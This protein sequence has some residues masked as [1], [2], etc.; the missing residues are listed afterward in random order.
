MAVGPEPSVNGRPG[1]SPWTSLLIFVGL[2]FLLSWSAW[3]ILLATGGD[4]TAGTLP[5]LLWV[6]GGF[7]PT[8]AALA[9]ARLDGRP[10]FRRLLRELIRWRVGWKWYLL[11]LLP[12]GVA[13]TS[14]LV[15]GADTSSDT[16]ILAA[17]TATLSAFLVNALVAGGNEELGW[18][19]YAQPS[20]QRIIRPLWASLVVGVIWALWH[21][22]L[23][24]MSGTSQ[25]DSSFIWFTI[26]AVALS[27]ILAWSYNGT[28]RS[29]LV[30]LLIHASVNTFYAAAVTFED[31]IDFAQFEV[32]ASL[33]MS[34]AA[35][36]VAILNGISLGRRRRTPRTQSPGERTEPQDRGTNT[37]NEIDPSNRGG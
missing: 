16:S 31:S 13:A 35:V 34:A 12:A 27:I 7:G 24:L 17:L 11:I 30:P 9:T 19:G 6:A 4:P 8:A 36:V 5:L 26:Q 25:A 3:G 32:V 37:H 22:P 1:H 14:L 18:R 15:I 29:I 23:Y 10:R 20:L 28:G 2:T 33:T 21:S